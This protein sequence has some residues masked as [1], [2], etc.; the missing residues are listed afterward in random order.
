MHQS[1]V[2]EQRSPAA[3]RRGGH[4]HAL[5]DQQTDQ[6]GLNHEGQPVLQF[7][8]LVTKQGECCQQG[9]DHEARSRPVDEPVQALAPGVIVHEHGDQA[10]HSQPVG[11][12]IERAVEVVDR[13]A[14]Q[15]GQVPAPAPDGQDD[16]AQAFADVQVASQE[17]GGQ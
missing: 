10:A 2:V 8:A 1:A 3:A 5:E 11:A 4:R 9:A 12:G 16:Q 13:G 7:A 6:K 14:G 15:E 17:P